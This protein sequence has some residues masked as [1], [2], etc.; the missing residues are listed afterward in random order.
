MIKFLSGQPGHGKTLRALVLAMELKKQGRAVYVEGIKDLDHEKTGFL[1][2][3][4][5]KDWQ[6][7]PDGAVVVVDEC[8]RHF[9]NRSAQSRTPDYIEALARH[10]HRGFDFI[11]VSQDPAKQV[12][13]F[14]R[15]LVDEHTHV[16]RKFGT[17][18]VV[19]KTW[20]HF[21]PS[22]LA[23][24]GRNVVWRY[25]KEVFGWYTSATMHTTKRSIPWWMFAVIPLLAFVGY[26]AWHIKSGSFLET[27][28]QTVSG[29]AAGG[30]ASAGKT[31]GAP[32]TAQQYIERNL[33]RIEGQPWTAPLY[34]D[35]NPVAKPEIYC[36]S[37]ARN[38]RC[39]T[40]Q[41]TRYIVKP[42]ICRDIARNGNYNPYREPPRE[43]RPAEASEPAV[44]PVEVVRTPAGTA[45]DPAAV[46]S[47]RMGEVWG[48][49]PETLRT[50][51][52]GG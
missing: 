47:S 49:A 16:R 18:N 19:L 12:D 5:P 27:D 6:N 8:Y 22:P 23:M 38:C 17:H 43:H 11:L 45:T 21:Q 28:A 34:D 39:I 32:L 42:R 50:S 24:D 7:L 46:G 4:N 14:L 36:M 44:E 13:P 41:G 40:E 25:P 35:A 52:V 2:L 48:K 9:P 3:E 15:G 30:P 20:D 10:R 37:S 33:P 31:A 29:A 1:P 26:V 51:N